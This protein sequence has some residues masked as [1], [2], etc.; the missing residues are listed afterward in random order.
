ML[1]FFRSISKV[2]SFR[3]FPESNTVNRFEFH[4]EMRS[5][6]N[7]HDFFFR[8]RV[9]IEKEGNLSQYIKKGFDWFS[10]HMTCQDSVTSDPGKAA[11]RVQ[12]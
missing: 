6:L 7:L 1:I 3:F 12:R 9:A 11:K 4:S 8:Q 5:N 10:C 2:K